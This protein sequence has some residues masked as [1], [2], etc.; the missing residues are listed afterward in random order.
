[1]KTCFPS[2]RVACSEMCPITVS[3]GCTKRTVEELEEDGE[4][5]SSVCK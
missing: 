1:M 5:N 3:H 4:C 2:T